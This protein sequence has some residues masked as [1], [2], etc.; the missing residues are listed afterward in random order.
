MESKHI[1]KNLKRKLQLTQLKIAKEIK[2]ICEKNNIKYFL[3]AGSMLGA[4]R[5][6]GFIPWD[7][8]MDIGMLKEDYDK[9]LK[10]APKELGEEFFLDNYKIDKTYGLVFSK[11]K[12][13]NTKYI[14]KIASKNAEHQEIF[15][16]IFPYFNVPEDEKIRKK[17]GKKLKL[18]AHVFMAQS[19]IKVW[20][21]NKGISKLKFLPIIILG[22]ILNKDKVYKNIDKIINK[23]IKSN[24]VG[25]H[26]GMSYNYLYF[27]KEYLN[28]FIDIEFE[29]DLFKIP[30]EYDKILKIDYGDY[31]KLP[32]KDKRV[33]HE[34]LELKC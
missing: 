24:L 22:K 7:D 9:F 4:V 13:K 26:D 32:P 14:E 11:V 31:M 10:I 1:N 21:N 17:Q 15:V 6:K 34:I 28:D 16:D 12:L 25:I 23:K 8:D 3:D 30:K 19:G 27:K 18:L 20:K 2:R 29:D 33:T 5:H